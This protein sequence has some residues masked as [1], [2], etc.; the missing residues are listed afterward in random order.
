MD[1]TTDTNVKYQIRLCNEIMLDSMIKL[2]AAGLDDDQIK[3][4]L[5]CIGKTYYRC[6]SS[7]KPIAYHIEHIKEYMLNNK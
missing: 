2:K 6:A 7:D 1:I 4:L 5:D 3:V